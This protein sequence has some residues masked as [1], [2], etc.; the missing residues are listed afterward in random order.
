MQVELTIPILISLVG[1]ALGVMAFW[2]SSRRDREEDLLR[3]EQR[4]RHLEDHRLMVDEFIRQRSDVPDR[5]VALEK[6]A[7]RT[8]DTIMIIR[9]HLP[10]ILSDAARGARTR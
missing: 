7:D 2:R 5:L 8:N 1:M 6:H 3:Q 9:D 10:R 4:V